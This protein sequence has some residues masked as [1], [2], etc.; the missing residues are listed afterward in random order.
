MIETNTLIMSKSLNKGYI[1]FSDKEKAKKWIK[2]LK[3]YR[4]SYV[5]FVI[6]FNKTKYY[7]VR[8]FRMKQQFLDLCGKLKEV[9]E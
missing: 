7:G 9:L 2:I 6:I 1:F 8:M 5:N 4:V 3:R